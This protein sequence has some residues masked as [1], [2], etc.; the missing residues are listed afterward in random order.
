VSK[1]HFIASSDFNSIYKKLP[2]TGTSSGEFAKFIASSK[3]KDI[4]KSHFSRIQ[5]INCHHLQ[6]EKEETVASVTSSCL[7]EIIPIN[8]YSGP[9]A[10][11]LAQEGKK[12][13]V[14]IFADSTNVGGIFI[15]SGFPA[16]TQEEQTV[17]MAPEIYSFLGKK[18]GVHDIGGHGDG[19]Y[20]KKQKRYCLNKKD[21]ELPD[22]INPA[23]GYILTNLLM[24]HNVENRLNMQKLPKEKV[25]EVSYAFLSMPSFATDISRDPIGAVLIG[26]TEEENGEI[27]YDNIKQTYSTL[28]CSQELFMN[29]NNT[30]RKIGKMTIFYSYKKYKEFAK[31]YLDESHSISDIIAEVL[32]IYFLLSEL[33][34]SEEKVKELLKVN[35]VSNLKK[36]VE[37]IVEEAQRNYEECI[38]EKF[39]NLVRGAEQAG[40]D[41]LILGKIGCGAFMN[42]ENEISVLMGRALSKCKTIKSIYFAAVKENDPFIKKVKDA[43][44]NSK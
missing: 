12:V 5:L 21:Y 25:V 9:A 31:K 7:P 4:F 28:Y 24:T 36:D 40:I 38:L 35:D 6:K 8:L 13:A 30:L 32:R 3:A 16:G 34:Y 33:G 20:G 11:K 22:V 23:Y 42:D 17:L 14:L 39:S 43:M 26:Q 10:L 2:D 41:T 15:T 37:S 18:Y 29:K 19:I 27:I 44:L 1:K